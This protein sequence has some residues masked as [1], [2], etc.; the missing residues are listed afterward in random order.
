[1]V[2]AFNWLGVIM[3]IDWLDEFL[4]VAKTAANMKLML[5]SCGNLSCKIDEKRFAI[6]ASGSFLASLE[7]K[8]ISICSIEDENY[9]EGPRPSIETSFHRQIYRN[10]PEIK[11]ILHFQSTYATTL[12]CSEQAAV[13]LNIIPEIPV[14]IKEVAVVP[15]YCPGSQSL[16]DAI[17]EATKNSDCRI[18]SLKNHGQIA[19]GENLKNMLRTAQFYE[20]A[21]EICCQNIPLNYIEGDDLAELKKF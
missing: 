3:N 5:S 18:V 10:R 1:M 2:D 21:A 11:A 13:N 16:T 20:L 7:A 6:S 15:Y 4:L 8:N 19:L 17:V 14:Y 9:H 12:A